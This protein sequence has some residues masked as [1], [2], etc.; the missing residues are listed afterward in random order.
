[1]RYMPG[2]GV[3]PGE[4]GGTRDA[5]DA[6]ANPHDTV[7]HRVVTAAE[8]VGAEAGEHAHKG[9]EADAHENQTHNQQ[10]QRGIHLCGIQNHQADHCDDNCDGQ[11]VDPA[12]LVGQAA[13]R[14]DG[15]RY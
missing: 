2:G 3:H 5:G 13:R 7:V 10:G 15:R 4:D 11:G 12:Q 9:A 14:S 1:M 6:E 8:L